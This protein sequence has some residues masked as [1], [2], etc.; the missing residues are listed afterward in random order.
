MADI[1]KITLPNNAEYDLKDA[2]ARSG[3]ANKQ[4]TLVSGTNIKTI[5]NESLLGSGNIT[6]Q[7]GG[8]D[9][10]PDQ[11]G[12]AGDY[13]TTDGTNASWGD[14]E[15]ASTIDIDTTV[16]ANSDHL[17]T[18]GAVATAISN[19]D[20][21]PSQTGNSGKFLTTDGTDASWATVDAL[22]SQTGNNGKYLTTNG[23]SAS[24]ANAPEEIF[25]AIYDTS[26]TSTSYNDVLA[27]YNAGKTIICKRIF[28]YTYYI[29]LTYYSGSAFYFC[30]VNSLTEV[31]T[32]WVNN[33]GWSQNSQN[34]VPSTRT[35]NSKELSSNITLDASDVGAAAS[36]HT[37]GNIQN[38]G[39]LQTTDVTVANGD[40]LVVT[41]ADATTADQ[42]AR[43]SIAFDGSTTN[44]YLS[45]KGT[46]ESFPSP[47]PIESVASSVDTI[48][49]TYN[50]KMI[51]VTG[52]SQV[53]YIDRGSFAA[54]D[55]FWVINYSTST[56]TIA[57][58]NA[59]VYINGDNGA[60]AVELKEQYQVAYFKLI[61]T[62]SSNEYWIATIDSAKSIPSASTTT[63]SMDG[64]A[65]YGSGTS[66]ARSNHVHPTDTSRAPT[67]HAST[68]TTYGTGTSSNYGHVKLSDS[69]S[70]T[71]GTSGGIA[72]TP[73][74]VK[75]VYDLANGAIP[76]PSS[77]SNG[78]VLT[79]N[80]SSWVASA[81]ASGLPTQSSSTNGK[82]LTS[83]YNSQTSTASASWENAPDKLYIGEFGVTTFAEILAAYNAGKTI[84]V[85]LEGNNNHTSQCLLQHIIE[86]TNDII[87][88]I[89]CHIENHTDDPW[90]GNVYP[91]FARWVK[92]EYNT[93]YTNNTHWD[94]YDYE[95]QE[96]VYAL[97]D[98]SG[99]TG[100]VLTVASNQYGPYCDWTD[101]PTE[102]PSQTGNSGKYLTTNGTTASWGTASSVSSLSID[103]APT[104]SSTNLVTSGGVYSA[105]A[106]SAEI[107]WCATNSA[108]SAPAGTTFNEVLSAVTGGKMCAIFLP[109]SGRMYVYGD[110][111]DDTPRYLNFYN[112]SYDSA[113]NNYDVRVWRV[114]EFNN[115][116][117]QAFASQDI[118]PVF[119]CEYGTT[120][121]TQ[122]RLAYLAGKTLICHKTN[123][124]MENYA[125]FCEYTGSAF[126]FYW[127][128][129]TLG[130]LT[131]IVY[132]IASDDT[133]S[134]TNYTAPSINRSTNVNATDTSYTTL[135]ARGEKLLD[136]TTYNAVSNWSTHL[137]NGAIAWRY[138]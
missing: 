59:H 2:T 103:S 123:S 112:F 62:D 117:E 127:M 37:H 116:W 126:T 113:L 8:G 81:P 25:L 102:L 31:R 15:S 100:K 97:S 132:S 88:F 36:S 13:L 45:P 63:P 69:T 49:N 136:A 101:I 55:E 56:V 121:Y 52:T 83:V 28:G 19:V 29:P 80:G 14:A 89:F 9:S 93:S 128:T 75:A 90:W 72:A 115:Q 35:V 47:R 12:H 42:V 118:A 10:L 24:W 34:L 27:A 96:N 20:A 108:G 5:N 51:E 53:L 64:T 17:I 110:C 109:Y 134:T 67:S 129:Y 125:A 137:V 70:S 85:E 77:P 78:N 107:F 106:N 135:M 22:P 44:K 58:T 122:V 76:K 68:A 131:K 98:L 23:S 1:S 73:S 95:L 79:Y 138:E 11:T 133:W 4:D 91:I 18:S 61:S 48:D 40:K 94:M 124:S 54:D 57:G 46:W 87:A 105:I 16:T 71:S 26:G 65:S 60:Y 41:D 92:C 7:G 86:G 74:A 38:N 119:Q 21:L 33:N 104:S 114:Y 120:T 43:A 99:N 3:L 111:S 30:H 50:H 82:V 32:F 84:L 6:I 130:A 66:Y 39:T